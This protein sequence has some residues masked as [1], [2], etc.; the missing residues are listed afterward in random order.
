M[1]EDEEARDPDFKAAADI[2]N[3]Y[4]KQESCKKSAKW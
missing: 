1:G 4:V 3:K 2:I